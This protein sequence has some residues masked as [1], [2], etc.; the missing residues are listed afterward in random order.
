MKWSHD[1]FEPPKASLCPAVFLFLARVLAHDLHDACPGDAQAAP[2]NDLIFLFLDRFHN[3]DNAAGI[4]D[5]VV[6]LERGDERLALFFLTPH[7]GDHQKIKEHRDSRK[8]KQTK[9]SGF[10][11]S[12]LPFAG[13]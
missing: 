9:P 1:P 11:G 8:W 6:F 3:A 12:L 4:D 13:I 5:L 2:K 10:R 7:G